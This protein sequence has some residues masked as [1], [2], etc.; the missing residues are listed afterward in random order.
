M[1]KTFLGYKTGERQTEK[2][3]EREKER[4]TE[5]DRKRDRHWKRKPEASLE[6]G[7]DLDSQR[8]GKSRR[9]KSE[10]PVAEGKMVEVYCKSSS[11]VA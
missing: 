6:I 1:R 2:Q 10:I 8:R 3:R 11:Q 7:Y 4:E 5:R 9:E